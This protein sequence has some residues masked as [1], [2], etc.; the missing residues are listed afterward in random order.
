MKT[1]TKLQSSVSSWLGAYATQAIHKAFA[2]IVMMHA[3]T[4]DD[5][6]RKKENKKYNQ[7]CATQ[8][9]SRRTP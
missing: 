4:R 7:R 1:I 6:K 9:V 2:V 3:E 8:T 5:Y